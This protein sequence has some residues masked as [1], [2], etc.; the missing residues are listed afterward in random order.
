MAAK[1][2]GLPVYLQAIASLTPTDDKVIIGNGTTWEAGDSP[3]GGLSEAAVQALIDSTV[4]RSVTQTAHDFAIGDVVR[5]DAAD[6]VKA[7]ADSG[8]NA[9]VVGMVS[10]V[11]DANT[12]S[13]TT[14]GYVSGLSGLTAGA[15][16]FL[17]PVTEGKITSTEP[18]T[19]G[20]ISKPV[21]IAVSTETGYFFNMRG[22]EVGGDAAVPYKVYTA[23]ITQSGTDAPV[24][25]VLAN[26][27][28]VSVTWIYTGVGTYGCNSESLF[29]LGK[30][31]VL[32]H[33][34]PSYKTIGHFLQADLRNANSNGITFMSWTQDLAMGPTLADDLV[35]HDLVEIRV[36]Q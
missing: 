36:Y 30:T 24:A 16:Y 18:T 3:G 23:L 21:F 22:A 1:T 34:D 10:L 5:M 25:N 27:V 15:T 9:E 2:N 29:T 6:Y 31:V 14:F 33:A 7:Q 4:A 8:E 35:D 28:G 20:Q 32:T 12:F 17:D 19:D 11:P 13:L 26:T